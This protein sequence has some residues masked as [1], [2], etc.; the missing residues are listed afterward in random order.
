[1]TQFTKGDRVIVTDGKAVAR[2]GTVLKAALKE[3]GWWYQ[4]DTADV[5]GD[6]WWHESQVAPAPRERAG[7]LAPPPEPEGM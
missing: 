7:F 6:L 2:P 3:L 1:M 4:V 5:H